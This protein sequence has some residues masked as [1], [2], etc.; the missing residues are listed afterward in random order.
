MRGG[1]GTI[2]DRP[3]LAENNFSIPLRPRGTRN[4]GITNPN[5]SSITAT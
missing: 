5:D 2:N 4:E 1:G 3:T